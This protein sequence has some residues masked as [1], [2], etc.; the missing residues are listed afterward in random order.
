MSKPSAT[1]TIE[2]LVKGQLVYLPMAANTPSGKPQGRLL[3]ELTIVNTASVPLTAAQLMI[4]FP[5]GPVGGS[6]TINQP[7]MPFSSILWNLP[8]GADHYQFDLASAPTSA[9]VSVS[10]T[11]YSDPISTT[12]PV[13]AHVGPELIGSY[14]FPSQA[15]DLDLGE[16]WQVNGCS[17]DPGN[18]Q[19]FAYDMGV[20]GTEHG[21]NEPYSQLTSGGDPYT[22]SAPNSDYRVYGKPVRAMAAGEVIEIVNTCPDNPAPLY[23]K[24][25]E[26]MTGLLDG[27]ATTY[28]AF[29]NGEAGNHVLVRHGDEVA[30]YAHLQKGS[31][32]PG[33]KARKLKGGLPPEPGTMISAGQFLGRAGNS[34]RSSAPHL[35]IHSEQ[36]PYSSGGPR[37][38]LFTGAWAIDNDTVGGPGAPTGGG[39]PAGG[40]VPLNGT[41]I[42]AG[43]PANGFTRDSF[44]L[45]SGTPRWPESVHYSVEEN[46]YQALFD[47]MNAK[48]M[49]PAWINTHTIEKGPFFFWTYVNVVFRPHL[50]RD[51]PAF[52]GLDATQLSALKTTQAAAGYHVKQLESYFSLRQGKQLF[53]GIFGRY[54]SLPPRKPARSYHAKSV[55]EHV[56][57]ISAWKA[58]G[59]VPTNISVVSVNGT[60]S[61]TALWEFRGTAGAD[62]DLREHIEPASMGTIFQQNLNANRFMTYLKGYVHQGATYY[63]AI[64]VKGAPNGKVRT[65]LRQP[66]FTSVLTQQRRANH[67][68]RSIS[69]YQ[70]D[71]DVAYAGI[72]EA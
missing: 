54:G 52:H 50:G 8:T 44:L 39:D 28:S 31:I 24:K 10:F 14:R 34:G 68:L 43:D 45:P 9:T 32:D 57:R 16:F 37:P 15:A 70:L 41:G 5:F 21:P 56:Q 38:M 71:G 2:P 7:V 23:P 13:V 27:L 67:L 20:W 22:K 6:R 63:S 47:A 19:A 53:A 18:H 4:T 17:H 69:G 61:Y 33:L 3:V 66:G 40:W 26:D 51:E 1:V 64:W 72:W 62:F 11:G 25:P 60:R 30:V 12:L 29:A 65:D 42:P 48:G 46:E 59:F 36:P 55:D 35:H 58:E 49:G